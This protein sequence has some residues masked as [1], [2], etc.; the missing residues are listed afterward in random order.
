MKNLSHS[1]KNQGICKSVSHHTCFPLMCQV[2][3]QTVTFGLLSLPDS[4]NII[5][6]KRQTT[7]LETERIQ[8][9]CKSDMQVVKPMHVKRTA[10]DWPV[11]TCTYKMLI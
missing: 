3:I 6:A 2:S 5:K 1:P 9:T 11:Y 7:L 8:Q 4:H 10:G